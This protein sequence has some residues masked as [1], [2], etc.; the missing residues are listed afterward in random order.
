ANVPSKSRTSNGVGDPFIVHLRSENRRAFWRSLHADAT[1]SSGYCLPVMEVKATT[2]S[3]LN[4]T[5]TG[6]KRSRRCVER[7]APMTCTAACGGAKAGSAPP[8][9]ANSH[10]NE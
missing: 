7:I 2:Q 9:T 8:G 6:D 1:R 3:A 5:P 4:S 10:D